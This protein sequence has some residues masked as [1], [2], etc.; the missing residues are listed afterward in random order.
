MHDLLRAHAAELA[1]GL[2]EAERRSSIHR[3]LDHYLHTAYA[4]SFLIHPY[5]DPISRPLP[6]PVV[7]PENLDGRLQAMQW[8]R[9][10]FQVL[11]GVI[12]Q[13]AADRHFS[14][15]AW[16]LPWAVAMFLNWDGHWH[17]LAATQEAAL[18]A[19]CRAGD[20]A[21]QAEAHRFLG[22]AQVRFGVLNEGTAHLAAVL[23]LGNQLGSITLQ[24]RAH[25]EL[26]RVANAG[27]Q[28]S[29]ALHH[30][31]QALR[32]YE[33]DHYLPGEASALNA[34]GWSC[35]LLG[36]HREALRH[37]GKAV[38]LNR[39]L[40]NKSGEA[41][42][43]DSMGYAHYQLGEYT[44]AVRCYQQSVEAFGDAD[45]A[46]H[47]AQAFTHLGDAHRE[48]GSTNAARRAWRQALTILEVLQHPDA[49]HLRTR[50]CRR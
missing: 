40:G 11:L 45:D 42:T 22:L 28:S 1:D 39:E 16:Q 27:G 50:L 48:S 8:F 36:R 7:C 31:N 32:L 35:V 34:A 44:H 12:G 2:A 23:D 33:A 6:L 17:E 20:H 13:A 41:A 37:C 30:A 18:A 10:E 49:E 3:M 29:D 26:G 47:R 5:R 38:A 43:L 24:A 4:A 9:A 46:H 25:L 15:H 19:A 14:E 21:G